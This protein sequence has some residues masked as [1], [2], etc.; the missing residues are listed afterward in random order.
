MCVYFECMFLKL[1]IVIPLIQLWASDLL[2]SIA[3]SG[4]VTILGKGV[5]SKH[6][7]RAGMEANQR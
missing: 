4:K 3:T 1:Y 2:V 6:C 5:R 7:N